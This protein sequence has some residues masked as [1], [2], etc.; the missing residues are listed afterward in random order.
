MATILYRLGRFSYRRRWVVLLSWLVVFVAAGAGAATLSGPT[1]DSF[2]IPDTESLEAF[3][4]MGERYPDAGTDGATARVVFEAPE[5]ETLADPANQAVVADVVAELNGAPQVAVAADPFQAGTV[6]PEGTI[7]FAQV[8]YEVPFEDITDDAR[9]ALLAAA[10]H[11]RDAGLTVEVGGEVV[12]QTGPEGGMSSELVALAIAAVVLV[13]T[14]GSFI[15]AG[16]PLLTAIVGIGVGIS[17]ITAATGFIDMGTSTTTLALMLGLAVAIDYALFIVSRYRHEL[18]I[19]RSGADAAGRAVGTAGSAVVFAGLTVMIA[20]AGLS[21]VGIPMLTEMGLAAAFTVGISVLI[22]LTLLPALLGFA[23]HRVLGGKIPGLRVRDPESD[24]EKPGVARKWAGLVTRYPKTVL[25]VAAAAMLGLAAPATDLRL[26]LPDEGTMAPDT[27]Q[28]KAYDLVS[29]GFGPGFNGP[30]I[31]LVDGIE[32]D[33]PQG[34]AA[35]VAA[36]IDALDGVEFVAP[37][38][39]NPA[40]DTALIN[41]IPTGGP[42]SSET[43]DLVADIRAAADGIETDTGAAV[44]VTGTTAITIDFSERMADALAPYLGV[45]VGLSFILLMLVFRS[46]LIPLKA[47]L[48]FLLTM[49]A[50][51]GVLVAIFQWGWFAGALGIE[52]TGPIISMLPIFLIGVVFGLAMDYQVFLVTRMREEYVHG[53]AP[54]PAVVTGFAHGGR[55]VTAAA[56]IM[57]S[58]FGGFVFSGE[59]FIMQIGLAMAAAVALDAFVVRMTIVPAVLTLLGRSAWWLPKWLDRL[60]PNVDVEGEKLRRMLDQKPAPP[61]ATP[62]PEPT[63]AR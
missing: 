36:E 4:L 27:T 8:N 39:P 22:A 29:E 44:A 34:A 24:D 13:L 47:A 45:V 18:A 48:G 17:A 30:L 50:T 54:T 60:L 7:G 28:R 49:G 56:I 51:F 5:G 12:Q 20:L 42:A 14:F 33:D 63:G 19:G 3:E 15:A 46:L 9:E 55:V 31:V 40:G 61:E 59:D 25:L 10:D 21:I 1:T 35:R 41:V 62:Q 11:G 23:K 38:V 2:E 53:A 37:P 57:I 43:E 26:G 6:A 58:V 16:M 52:Q 32:A